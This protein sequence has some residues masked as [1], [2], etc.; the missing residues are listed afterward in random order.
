MNHYSVFSLSQNEQ[1]KRL[2]N[3]LN[4]LLVERAFC[5]GFC[6]KSVC[7]GTRAHTHTHSQVGFSASECAKSS[8]PLHRKAQLWC[9][10][11]GGLQHPSAPLGS[12][13]LSMHRRIR[14]RVRWRVSIRAYVCARAKNRR[15][16]RRVCVCR[17]T[18]VCVF[19]HANFFARVFFI[20][21]RSCSHTT[22]RASLANAGLFIRQ[23]SL[24]GKPNLCFAARMYRIIEIMRTMKTT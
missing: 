18:R 9:W 11:K 16:Y 14:G 12:L 22:T 7:I 15:A 17:S 23:T 1:S 20:A 5:D 8:R 2:S 21:Q 19:Y 10:S 6:L 24:L 3:A 4:I 13:G